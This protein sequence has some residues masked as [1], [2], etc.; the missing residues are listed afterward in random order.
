MK[1]GFSVII[2]I[3]AL[4]IL[5][6][7]LGSVPVSVLAQERNEVTIGT[8]ILNTAPSMVSIEIKPDDDVVIPGVQ[9]INFN[10]ATNKTII[11]IANVSDKNGYDDITNV[12]AEI[13]GPSIVEGSIVN[14]TFDSAINITTA[15][16]KGYFNMFNY[17]EGD[18]KVEIISTDAGGL[19]GEGSKN[20]TYGY[21][22]LQYAIW[23]NSTKHKDAIHWS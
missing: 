8:N 22:V 17:S 11:I 13:T 2:A 5:L 21:R 19:T 4:A 7:F 1:I 9:V 16:Y 10:P 18:Y 12:T 15:T 23:A 6:P 14:L 20:F 3:L